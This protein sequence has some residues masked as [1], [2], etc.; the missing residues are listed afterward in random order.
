MLI[1]NQ[2]DLK[3]GKCTCF[4]PRFY[5]KGHLSVSLNNISLLESQILALTDILKL[6]FV[7]TLKHNS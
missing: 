5:F 7:P 4:V 1:L 3:K 6:E 2:T